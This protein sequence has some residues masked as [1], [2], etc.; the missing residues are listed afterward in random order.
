[1][2]QKLV[3]DVKRVYAAREDSEHGQALVRVVLCGIAVLLTVGLILNKAGPTWFLVVPLLI[4]SAALVFGLIQL[5]WIYHS[6]APSPLR[7]I[8]AM[9]VD[10]SAIC[11]GMVIGG[12]SF[13]FAY[14]YLLWV[15]VGYGLRYGNQYLV[16]SVVVGVISFSIVL[17]ATPFWHNNIILGI[18]LLIG[19]AAMPDI[20][21]E[22][23][24]EP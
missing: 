2:L 5:V 16:G 11:S 21:A 24:Q 1:M 19:I 22:A 12:E 14:I 18:A 23:A 9:V 15:T 13:S 10:Y 7:R 8:L 3:K 4:A 6:P 20:S 17:M